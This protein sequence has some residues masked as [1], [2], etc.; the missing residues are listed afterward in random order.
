MALSTHVEKYGGG[1][2][3]P[4]EEKISIEQRLQFFWKQPSEEEVRATPS[5]GLAYKP[6]WLN[7]LKG[8]FS[9][10][11][12]RNDTGEPCHVWWQVSEGVQ[13]GGG[14][15]SE[16][17]GP[18]LETPKKKLRANMLH[19]VCIKYR[20]Q[21]VLPK[22]AWETKCKMKQAP[23][24]GKHE[25][26]KVSDIQSSGSYIPTP[27][28]RGVVKTIWLEDDEEEARLHVWTN[29]EKALEAKKTKGSLPVVSCSHGRE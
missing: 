14:Y 3:I 19:E 12:I 13:T 7:D 8:I 6:T 11:S 20:T 26:I 29:P 21:V 1:I 17:L 15:S 24:L 2:F 25:I 27:D 9:H 4:E 5:K 28:M 22:S 18:G 23:K 10:E 16:Q